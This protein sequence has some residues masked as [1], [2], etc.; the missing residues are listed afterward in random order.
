MSQILGS[1][2]DPTV[3]GMNTSVRT[4]TGNS[5]VRMILSFGRKPALIGPCQCD[6]RLCPELFPTYPAV[7]N[8]RAVSVPAPLSPA[9]APTPAHSLTRNTGTHTAGPCP[10]TPHAST[11]TPAPTQRAVLS[12]P[13]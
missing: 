9:P 2:P 5:I 8:P 6:A 11:T 4:L 13:D 12:A 10:H 3:P 7:S 1:A